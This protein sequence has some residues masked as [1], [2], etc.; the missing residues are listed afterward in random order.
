MGILVTMEIVTYLGPLILGGDHRMGKRLEK[1]GCTVLWVE[2]HQD[3]RRM[4][5]AW[6]QPK[7]KPLQYDCQRQFRLQNGQILSDAC[8][9]PQAKRNERHRMLRSAGPALGESSRVEFIC[10]AA[11]QGLIMM[12]GQDWNQNLRPTRDPV[13]P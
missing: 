11:P 9:D 6:R 2:Q 13:S 8:T 7:G 1:D 4:L 12:N 5:I 10:I 3:R